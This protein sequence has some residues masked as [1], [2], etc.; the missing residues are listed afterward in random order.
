MEKTLRPFSTGTEFM[1]W[2]VNNCEQCKKANMK[3]TDREDTCPMEYDMSIAS[4]SDGLIPLES[5]EKI[6][7]KT[8]PYTHL[9][10]CKEKQAREQA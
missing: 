3:A 9:L 7:Y 2:S 1:I 8:K 4:I 10:G 6:G 5:A